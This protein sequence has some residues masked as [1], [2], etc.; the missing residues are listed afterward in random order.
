[1]IP[2]DQLSRVTLSAIARV[3]RTADKFGARN[4]VNAS[5]IHRRGNSASHLKPSLN[6]AKHHANTSSLLFAM[7]THS[8]E[9]INGTNIS[10]W[11]GCCTGIYRGQLS[12]KKCLRFFVSRSTA[13]SQEQSWSILTWF[14]QE[15]LS[16]WINSRTIKGKSRRRSSRIE[17]I[18]AISLKYLH[19]KDIFWLKI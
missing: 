19:V 15:Y 9:Q 10:R 13:R 12:K 2:D 18:V 1:M 3:E 16:P 6:L 7:W 14:E 8:L 11:G 4:A 5:I 17:I